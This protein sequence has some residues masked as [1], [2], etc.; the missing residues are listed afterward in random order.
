MGPVSKSVVAD[1]TGVGKRSFRREQFTI[2]IRTSSEDS[3]ILIDPVNAPIPISPASH[4]VRTNPND[5]FTQCR[6]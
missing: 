4:S 1:I 5:Y 6:P 2:G 3:R